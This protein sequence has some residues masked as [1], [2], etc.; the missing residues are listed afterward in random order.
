MKKKIILT[1]LM[2]LFSFNAQADV[3]DWYTYWGVGFAINSYPSEVQTNFDDLEGGSRL[4]LGVDSFGFYWPLTNNDILGFVVSGSSDGV[5]GTVIATNQN[6]EYK[7]SQ[8]LYALSGMRFFGKEIGT[9]FFVRGDIGFT[10]TAEERTNFGIEE[11]RSGYGALGGVGY[12]IAVSN[13][14]RV[15]LGVTAGRNRLDGK[16]YDSIRLMVGGLW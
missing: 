13:E 1:V 5:K 3:E 8:F 4:S 9:G 16:S 15:L 2:Y 7:L 14:S 11:E 12:A 10:L 6:V